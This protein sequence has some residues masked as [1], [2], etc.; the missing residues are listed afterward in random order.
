MST[1]PTVRPAVCPT[2]TTHGT[3]TRSPGVPCWVQ[4]QNQIQTVVK[5]VCGSSLAEQIQIVKAAMVAEAHDG[6]ALKR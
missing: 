5:A 6:L 2:G 4:S 1:C 3:A